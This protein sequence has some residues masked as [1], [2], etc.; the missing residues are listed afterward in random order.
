MRDSLSSLGVESL[1]YG[2]IIIQRKNDAREVFTV[3]RSAG[4]RTGR[5]E[6]AWLLKWE[7]FAAGRSAFEDLQGMIPV[8]RRSLELRAIHRMKEGELL[9]EQLAFHTEEPFA[10][11]C[12]VDPWVAFLV[13]MCDGQ[14]TVRATLG[15]VQDPQFRPCRNPSSG[16]CQV[17]RHPDFWRIP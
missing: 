1:A 9:P 11:N 17:Y 16:I 13:P 12:R 2:W 6:I 8:A 14:A 15:E 7:T 10:M 4:L 5:E 3:R